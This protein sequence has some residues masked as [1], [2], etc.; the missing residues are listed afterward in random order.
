MEYDELEEVSPED[1][2]RQDVEDY[3]ATLRAIA[4]FIERNPE[5]ARDKALWTV[6]ADVL[7]VM[8]ELD[9]L[10]HEANEGHED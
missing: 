4:D 6:C 7:G 5:I 3:A 9:D 1:K 8:G 2:W 10:E